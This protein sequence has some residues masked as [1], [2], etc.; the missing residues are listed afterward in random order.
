MAV[1]LACAGSPEGLIPTPPPP[2]DRDVELFVQRRMVD[3]RAFREQGRLE[4]AQ[5]ALER[6]LAFAPD[7][8]AVHRLLARVLE[9]QGQRSQ[10]LEHLARADA[11]D[12][13]APPPPDAP[14]GVESEG[15]VVFLVGGTDPPDGADARARL[16]DPAAERALLTA[17]LKTRLPWAR[18][19]QAD[20]GSV[21]AARRLLY[22]NGARAAF[23]LHTERGFCGYS[24]KDGDFAVAWL[25]VAGATP[26]RLVAP[27]T[28]VREV[29]ADPPAGDACLRL[30]LARALEK[31]L[32]E[33]EA[34]RAAG[35]AGEAGEWPS[36]ALRALF[37]GIGRRVALEIERGRARL[38]TGRVGE[39]A[40]AFRAAVVLDPEDPD[41]RAYLREAEDTLAIARALS[42]DGADPRAE[43][44]QLAFSL[45]PA[46]RAIAEALLAEERRRRDELLAALVISEVEERPPGAEAVATLR[47]IE[48]PDPPAPGPRLARERVEGPVEA[49]ASYGGD[50]S[51]VAVYYFAAGGTTPVLREEDTTS[52]GRPD[53]WIGYRDGVRSDVWEARAGAA[54][55]D[56]HVQFGDFGMSVEVIEVDADG[57]GRPERV[58]RYAGE[59]LASEGRDTNGDGVLDRFETFDGDGRVTVREEDL[60]ADGHPDVRTRYRDGR[61]VSREIEDPKKVEALLGGE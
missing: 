18:V 29:M 44:G 25:R 36:P 15:L 47:P 23:S 55:P 24:R 56:V 30:V 45:T 52:D 11:L 17:R 31:A 60:D 21:A 41:A 14:L 7:D 33:T 26:Q 57:D 6:A 8:P 19:V 10:A 22:D 35:E 61:L 42:P 5:R 38:V 27:P 2:T 1:L 32:L 46:E 13:P 28:T 43:E 58:F 3:A 4:A 16:P 53:R 49:R 51:P 48:L 50:G 37:P 40:E 9:E 20:P 12:P 39:A 34:L 54:A 59:R